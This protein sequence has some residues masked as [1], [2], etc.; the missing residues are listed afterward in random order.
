M[1]VFI[2]SFGP[3]PRIVAKFQ[4]HRFRTFGENPGEKKKKNK[5]RN[6]RAVKQVR[7]AAATLRSAVA[8]GVNKLVHSIC[9]QIRNQFRARI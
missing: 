4:T 7:S 1:K 8:G 3:N 5:E 2:I 6:P 9:S